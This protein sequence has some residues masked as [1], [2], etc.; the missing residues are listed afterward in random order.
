MANITLP[1]IKEEE[2][3]SV[4]WREYCSSLNTEADWSSVEAANANISKFYSQLVSEG[5]DNSGLPE[6]ILD[7]IAAMLEPEAQHGSEL[8]PVPTHGLCVLQRA[9]V[10]FY[11]ALFRRTQLVPALVQ[12]AVMAS[13]TAYLHPSD[14]V[15]WVKLHKLD[16]LSGMQML[17][18]MHVDLLA[19]PLGLKV[20][21]TYTGDMEKNTFTT[22][23][24][25]IPFVS[26]DLQ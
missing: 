18:A 14:L 13:K 16:D 23:P 24:S 5:L 20:S 4:R 6:E 8:T 3:I 9:S 10:A 15:P 17:R 26:F 2:P 1:A 11:V 19:F 22:C 21:G 12:H 7:K 25:Y